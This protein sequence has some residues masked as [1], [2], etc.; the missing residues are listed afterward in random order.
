LKLL[1]AGIHTRPAVASAKRLGYYISAVDY[2]GDMDLR[3]IADELRSIVVQEPG[4]SCGRISENYSDEK[5]IALAEEVEADYTILTSTLEL[6]RSNILGNPTKKIKKLKN[7]AYQLRKLKSIVNIPSTEI[8]KTREEA[9]EIAKNLGFPVVVKPASGAGGRGIVYARKPEEIPEYEEEYILQPFIA[10][11]SFSISLVS[12]G[13][14]ARAITS[15]LQILGFKH[16]NI[17][18]FTYCGSLSPYPAP[19]E[20]FNLAEAVATKLK[21]IGWNGVD[22]VEHR[23]EIYFMEVNPRFQG[24]L[25]VVER[26]YG[27]N[28]VDAHIKACNGELIPQPKPRRY[29]VRLTLF[30]GVRSRVSQNLLGRAMDVPL[31]GCIIE[32]GEPFATVV[33][34]SGSRAL[35]LAKAKDK[36]A[37][38]RKALTPLQPQFSQ[39]KLQN[40]T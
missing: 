21:L 13:R 2:F 37:N 26:A 35:A 8:C 28:I 15:A 22:F 24:T 19:E 4:K 34:C 10:G 18:G 12:T 20:A 23:G 3:I 30:A 6:E 39:D 32:E 33:A 25:D 17:S 14:R 1:I 38:L 29:C 7:K 31:K 16:C 40:Q 11:R 5:L 36:A 9:I 27:I